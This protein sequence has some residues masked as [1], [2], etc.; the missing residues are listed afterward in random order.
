MSKALLKIFCHHCFSLEHSVRVKGFSYKQCL[1]GAWIMQKES[2]ISAIRMDVFKGQVRPHSTITQDVFPDNVTR[3][4][5]AWEVD[6]VCELLL[7]FGLSCL[8][9]HQVW[10]SWDQ[11]AA[12]SAH[13]IPW[14]Q[15]CHSH[16]VSPE[17]GLWYLI[18]DLALLPLA[19]Q[20]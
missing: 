1:D 14:M 20:F 4:V 7:S 13:P 16:P 19:L 2:L 6:S 15:T 12:R 18:C 10:D 5:S 17:E 9:P 8:A 3:T 11:G